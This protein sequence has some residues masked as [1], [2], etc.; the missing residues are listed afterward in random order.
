MVIVGI[1]TAYETT[2]VYARTRLEGWFVLLQVQSNINLGGK[3]RK[4][5]QALDGRGERERGN[6]DRGQ[7]GIFQQRGN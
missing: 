2:N 6:W 4:T 5:P 3:Q 7:Y 1:M